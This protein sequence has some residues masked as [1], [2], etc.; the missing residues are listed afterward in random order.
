L[1]IIKNKKITN[2]GMFFRNFTTKIKDIKNPNRDIIFDLSSI[3]NT[4]KAID[5]KPVVRNKIK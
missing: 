4:I 5:N 1:Y 3:K 2:N